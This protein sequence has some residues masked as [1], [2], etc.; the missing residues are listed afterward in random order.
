MEDFKNLRVWQK[1]HE[2]TLNIYR[3]SRTFPNEE[4]YGLTSQMKRAAASIGANLAEGCGRR[5]D[6]RK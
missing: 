1:T 4:R 6:T 5:A 2:V 3:K